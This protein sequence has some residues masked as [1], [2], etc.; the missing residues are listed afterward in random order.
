MAKTQLNAFARN[1]RHQQLMLGGVVAVLLLMGMAPRNERAM[2]FV[3]PAPGTQV[4]AA[5]VPPIG[6][7]PVTSFEDGTAVRRLARDPFV[8][9]S[10]AAGGPPA[11]VPPTSSGA[12]GPGEPSI[13][14]SA[15]DAPFT[16]P[17]SFNSSP[18]IR[19]PQGPLLGGSSPAAPVGGGDGI[20]VAPIL[21]VAP[22]PEPATWAMLIVGF[23]IVGAV[24]RRR[25]RANNAGWTRA[26]TRV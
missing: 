7:L 18:A 6:Y 25:K 16:Q 13:I 1:H 21:P 24:L 17:A 2:F 12:G 5:I 3:P 4:F 19:E 10:G 8:P 15:D 9:R 26:T 23:S 14:P 22:V 11:I 20:G